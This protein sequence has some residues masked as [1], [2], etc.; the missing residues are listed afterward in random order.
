MIEAI[1][2]EFVGITAKRLPPDEQ[3]GVNL[4]VFD[5]MLP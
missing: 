2:T 4:P 1:V 3:T 5:R